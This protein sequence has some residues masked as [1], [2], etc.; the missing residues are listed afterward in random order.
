MFLAR[1]AV[2]NMRGPDLNQLLGVT[3]G[4]TSSKHTAG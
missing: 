4:D 2:K 3:D 1:R